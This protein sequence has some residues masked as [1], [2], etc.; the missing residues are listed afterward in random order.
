[1]FLILALKFNRGTK[2]KQTSQPA[3]SST[4]QPKPVDKTW[5]KDVIL[6]PSPHFSSVPKF[7]VREGLCE[8]KSVLSGF[9]LHY[10]ATE[11]ELR[12][13]FEAA[14][15]DKFAFSP[16]ENK[17]EFAHAVEKK[18]V[19]IRSTDEITGEVL[20]QFCG[21]R[22]Q[23]YPDSYYPTFGELDEF[24]GEPMEKAT[25]ITT[26]QSSSTVS[27]PLVSWMIP[28]EAPISV[29]NV[30]PSPV[31]SVSSSPSVPAS[32]NAVPPLKNANISTASASADVIHSI[33]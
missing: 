16:V 18:I 24:Y 22:V 31:V 9:I 30:I 19:K 3:P 15:I 2:R 4:K 8:D 23:I 17:F 29:T 14:F 13:T 6:I 5:V 12:N 25:I 10:L 1:M 27:P 28:F 26:T 32:T 11:K 20:K 21:S 7:H 33:P